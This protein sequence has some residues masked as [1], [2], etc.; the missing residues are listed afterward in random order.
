MRLTRRRDRAVVCILRNELG[1][2]GDGGHSFCMAS[3]SRFFLRLDALRTI[4]YRPALAATSPNANCLHTARLLVAFHFRVVSLLPFPSCAIA[5]RLMARI[6]LVDV[7]LRWGP[8]RHPDRLH[9]SRY[10]V[11]AH[12]SL[13]ILTCG[14]GARAYVRASCCTREPS[15]L[16]DYWCSCTP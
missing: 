13:S 11:C 14:C 6:C 15:P 3:L 12:A 9:H 10:L 2:K 7:N 8:S 16:R 5:C 4:S 1:P